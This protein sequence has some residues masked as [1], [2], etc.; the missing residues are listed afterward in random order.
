MSYVV[1]ISV[2]L[3][4]LQAVG[5]LLE[6]RPYLCISRLGNEAVE[7]SGDRGKHAIADMLKQHT[8]FA[9]RNKHGRNPN[10]AV[11][12]SKD[13]Y[14]LLRITI[15]TDEFY[16]RDSSD[17]LTPAAYLITRDHTVSDF[18]VQAQTMDQLE[19]QGVQFEVGADYQD[20]G[21]WY[22]GNVRVGVDQQL[23]MVMGV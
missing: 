3:Q 5:K 17:A 16:T 12:V 13:V 1:K 4:S 19:E 11:N 2:R 20:N 10:A 14:N 23:A 21:V 8:A 22:P 7:V 15:D 18:Y 9:L 6:H